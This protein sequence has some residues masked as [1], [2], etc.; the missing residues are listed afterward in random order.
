MWWLSGVDHLKYN[1][2][3]KLK[4]KAEIRN[5]IIDAQKECMKNK[6]HVFLVAETD[7]FRAIMGMATGHVGDREDEP[8]L[9]I[10]K[11]GFIDELCVIEEFREKGV[12]TQLLDE[13][14]KRLYEKGAPFIGLGV[15]V[16][17]PAVAFYQ[18]QGFQIKSYW[19]T[20]ID[21]KDC[22]G[23]YNDGD[24]ECEACKD[25]NACFKEGVV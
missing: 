5:T 20:R 12:G 10:D 4:P 1:K 19:M 23:H 25:D 11:E 14:I 6:D 8:A 22:F 18:K 3:D 7:D 17:N 16:Q 15:A 24:K 21:K 9:V 13:L 2:L